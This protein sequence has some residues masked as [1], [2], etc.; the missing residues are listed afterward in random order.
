MKALKKSSKCRGRKKRGNKNLERV[1]C[2]QVLEVVGGGGGR[3]EEHLRLHETRT[4][5]ECLQILEAKLF[6]QANFCG[7]ENLNTENCTTCV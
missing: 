6:F 4:I 5:K 2:E 1:N 3:E 7:A